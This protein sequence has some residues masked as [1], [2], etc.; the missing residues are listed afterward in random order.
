MLAH[1]QLAFSWNALFKL[2]MQLNILSQCNAIQ[3]NTACTPHRKQRPTMSKFYSTR[4]AAWISV[5]CIEFLHTFGI[6]QKFNPTQMESSALHILIA[7]QRWA[8]EWIERYK[9]QGREKERE[10]GKKMDEQTDGWTN[11]CIVHLRKGS[12]EWLIQRKV[13]E[14]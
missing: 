9:E 6:H 3:Q 8:N 12:A 4:L 5:A 13:G 11:V 1:I 7:F 10:S 2:N 14:L